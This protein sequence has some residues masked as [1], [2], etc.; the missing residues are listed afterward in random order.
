[1][2]YFIFILIVFLNLS[3]ATTKKITYENQE[4]Y[5]LFKESSRCKP[6][7]EKNDWIEFKAYWGTGKVLCDISNFDHVYTCV[8]VKP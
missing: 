6:T 2:K 3:C 5:N 8:I 1:M 7:Y 4:D